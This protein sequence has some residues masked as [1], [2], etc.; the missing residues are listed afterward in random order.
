[1]LARSGIDSVALLRIN[2][3]ENEHFADILAQTQ[4]VE[5]GAQTQVLQMWRIRPSEQNPVTNTDKQSV[6]TAENNTQSV[7]GDP[8]IHQIR[9]AA[10]AVMLLLAVVWSVPLP[11]RA[12]HARGITRG[13]TR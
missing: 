3:P 12:R 4:G 5:V 8:F 7:L 9:F 11:R 13:G 10:L 1:M 2:T 6:A